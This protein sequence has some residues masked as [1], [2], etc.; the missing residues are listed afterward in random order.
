MKDRRHDGRFAPPARPDL[1]ATLRPGCA[2][3]LV[4]LSACGALVQTPCPLR[5]GARVHLQVI[6]GT[7]R[8]AVGAHILRCQVW[9]LDP[10]EGVTYR[11]AL[12]F[13]HRVEWAWADRT[14]RVHGMPEH[15]RPAAPDD[16]KRI[17]RTQAAVLSVVGEW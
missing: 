11:G 16:E 7:R 10:S 5:P 14:R 8:V 15:T 13:D 2:V 1:R 6:T 17:P 9:S 3:A 12:K 4:D